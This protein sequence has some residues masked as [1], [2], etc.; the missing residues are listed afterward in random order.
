MTFLCQ[1]EI[2]RVVVRN[3]DIYEGIL[4]AVSSK[5]RLIPTLSFFH[6]VRSFQAVNVVFYGGC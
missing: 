1:G 6:N 2:A 3:G 5:V 4:K